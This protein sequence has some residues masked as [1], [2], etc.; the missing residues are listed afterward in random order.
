ME[1]KYFAYNESTLKNNQ[2]IGDDFSQKQASLDK[3]QD[4]DIKL[5]KNDNNTNYH[6]NNES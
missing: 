6:H 3:S 4:V 1:V 2:I 5:V